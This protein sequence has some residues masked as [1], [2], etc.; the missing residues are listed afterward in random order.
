MTSFHKGRILSRLHDDLMLRYTQN[1]NDA[2]GDLDLTGLTP[3]NLTLLWPLL[4]LHNC[5]DVENN[6]RIEIGSHESIIFLCIL[7]VT[8]FNMWRILDL[9]P[10]SLPSGH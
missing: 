3:S 10:S 9:F 2:A 1:I 8:S 7:I 6:L 5:L 4:K